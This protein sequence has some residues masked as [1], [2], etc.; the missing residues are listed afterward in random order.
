MGHSTSQRF[1]V[2]QA[3][4]IS[5]VTLAGILALAWFGYNQFKG[6]ENNLR[7]VKE[8]VRAGKFDQSIA[9]ID[10]LKQTPRLYSKMAG[11][12]LTSIRRAVD[13]HRLCVLNEYPTY[14]HHPGIQGC[15]FW[16]RHDDLERR[17]VW[18][19]DFKEQ[20]DQGYCIEKYPYVD[21][22]NTFRKKY[23]LEPSPKPVSPDLNFSEGA[24]SDPKCDYNAY[25]AIRRENNWQYL[26]S[27][28]W[29]DF[30]E[31]CALELCPIPEKLNF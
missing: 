10:A 8:L 2:R 31:F 25:K 11:V 17:E 6:F 13:E 7:E 20:E 19:Q 28:E 27:N 15:V 14:D 26:T 9:V 29:D 22:S 23:G 1:F 12:E 21:P 4:Y 5:A 24:H 18:I 3:I 30:T 16:M